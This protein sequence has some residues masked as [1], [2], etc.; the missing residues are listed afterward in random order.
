MGEYLA[1]NPFHNIP[2]IKDGDFCLNESRACAAYLANK[3]GPNGTV[4]PTD[5]EARAIVDQR[6]YL[7]GGLLQGCRRL[8]IPSYVRWPRARRKGERQVEGGSWLGG[9]FCQ[10]RQVRRW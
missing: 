6:M 3:Y 2:A 5:P 1:I 4:Y 9:R 7:Y 10:G 8:C